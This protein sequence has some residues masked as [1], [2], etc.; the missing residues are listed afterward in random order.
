MV[1]VPL[2]P[3]VYVLLSLLNWSLVALEKLQKSCLGFKLEP[4]RVHKKSQRET[5][6]RSGWALP[7][8]C[9]SMGKSPLS[10]FS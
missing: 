1:R 5:A 3:T 8:P 7:L 6:V 9:P 2:A 4:D 10:W